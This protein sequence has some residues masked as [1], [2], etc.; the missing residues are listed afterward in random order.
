[1]N[2]LC[3]QLDRYTLVSNSDAHSC[4]RLGR[5]ANLLDI[6]LSYPALLGALREGP[7]R[8]FLGTVELFPE[9]GKYHYDGHRA[10]G[11]C[12]DPARTRS[13]GSHCPVCG[14]ELT[15]GVLNRVLQLADRPD[16]H[17]REGAADYTPLVPLKELVSEILGKGAQTKAVAAAYEGLLESCGS[18]LEILLSVPVHDIERAAGDLVAEAVRRVREREVSTEPGYDGQYGKVRVF[19]PGEIG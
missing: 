19:R 7:P 17:R 5:E 9:E 14:R 13:A 4:E 3:A 1:M 6:E 16:G 10:C 12:Q 8:G 2:W 18:E 15:Q 11:V